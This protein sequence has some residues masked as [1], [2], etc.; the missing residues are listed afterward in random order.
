[1]S[2]EETLSLALSTYSLPDTIIATKDSAS[3]PPL[4]GSARSIH[5]NYWL[6]RTENENLVRSPDYWVRFTAIVDRAN[7]RLSDPQCRADLLT[8]KILILEQLQ[9]GILNPVGAASIVAFGLKYDQ[10]VAWRRSFGLASNTSLKSIHFERYKVGLKNGKLLPL[11]ERVDDFF[12]QLT[13]GVPPVRY[14]FGLGGFAF[15]WNQ[16]SRYV[17]VSNETLSRT[18]EVRQLIVA[19]LQAIDDKRCKA[20]AEKFTTEGKTSAF[21]GFSPSSL[22]GYI[23]VWSLLQNYSTN[24]RLPA[25]GLTFNPFEKFSARQLYRQLSSKE[26]GRTS[27]LHPD[28]FMR[29][30]SGATKWA[31]QNSEYII[32]TT[33]ALRAA[34]ADI[35]PNFSKRSAARMEAGTDLESLRPADFAP[36][37][38]TW[39]EVTDGIR[40]P[41]SSA[42]RALAGSVVIITGC[43]G[44]RRRNELASLRTDCIERSPSGNIALKIYI[45]KTHRNVASVPVPKV[46]GGAVNMLCQLIAQTRSLDTPK[47]LFEI[48]YRSVD[49]FMS[50]NLTNLI[51]E[52]VRF[53][54]IPPPAGSD[55]WVI[56]SHMLRRGFAIFYYHGFEQALIDPLVWML[57][58]YDPEMTRIYIVKTL[59][60]E[61]SRLR[62]QLRARM[63][64]A[65]KNRTAEDEKEILE[66]K[67]LL[68]QKV[69]MQQDFSEVRCEAF[70]YKLLKAHLGQEVVRG[71]GAKKFYASVSA[72]AKMAAADV[73]VTS[74]SNDLERFKEAFL[75]RAKK[76][77]ANKWM[78]PVPGG[79]MHC[80]AEPD[81]D[82]DL[83]EAEC[84]KLERKSR[85]PWLASK[86]EESREPNF[87]FSGAYPCIKCLHGCAFKA[88]QQVL[89]Q[90]GETLKRATVSAA[91]PA[92][93]A[94]AEAIYAEYSAE[95]DALM[96][97]EVTY[98]ATGR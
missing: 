3:D 38:I 43:Y 14:V 87:A 52:F 32:A 89:A 51:R 24:G 61:I 84:L 93:Q 64:V 77:V 49:D 6:V 65:K 9:G 92:A 79:V 72:I 56:K 73:R 66:A 68:R 57:W 1:M 46:V 4:N 71:K 8:K 47:W 97:E 50:P 54:N 19:R 22:K 23:K 36:L 28:D 88:N 33:A 76:W 42:I 94:N 11:V 16:L 44:A 63:A 55:E 13:S 7:V 5:H 98:D 35:L 78:E 34:D 25:N 82:N 31:F 26:G 39:G 85:K 96:A 83:A 81:N 17:G 60:G 90:K 67:F 37:A 91:T 80:S 58:H 62:E 30:I 48:N 27:T 15:N 53:A 18:H 45:E 10:F 86:V 20:A 59:P 21:T 95:L 70:A 75:T 74:R 2:E 12:D 41:V 40:K 69:E 29:L